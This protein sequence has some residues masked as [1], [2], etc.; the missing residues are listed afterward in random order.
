MGL[1]AISFIPEPVLID[2]G[3]GDTKPSDMHSISPYVSTSRTPLEDNVEVRALDLIRTFWEKAT[4]LHEV[5]NRPI[6]IPL[7]PRYSRHYYDLA[8]MSAGAAGEAALAS[9][10]MLEHV[11]RFKSVFFA[12]N[13]AHYELARPGTLLL[14]CGDARQREVERDYEAMRSDMIFGDAPSWGDVIR[15]IGEFEDKVNRLAQE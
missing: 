13:R 11:A 9:I 8:I 7:H 14:R 1:D 3:T 12:S 5:A 4:I 10:E 15:T 2:C 6:E